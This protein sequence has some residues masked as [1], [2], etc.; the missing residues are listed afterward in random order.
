MSIFKV[1]MIVVEVELSTDPEMNTENEPDGCK[2]SR[3][4]D[5][6]EFNNA[7]LEG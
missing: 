4:I 3:E 5:P 7:M 2:G 1:Y 6:S